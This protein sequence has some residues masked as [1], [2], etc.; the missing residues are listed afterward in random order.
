[1]R[2][3]ALVVA[4]ASAPMTAWALTEADAGKTTTV[5]VGEIVDL[6][7]VENP[8]TGYV[9]SLEVEPADAAAIVSSDWSRADAGAP[10]LRVGAPGIRTFNLA[11][12][13]TGNMTLR[14][15]L[16]R[17]WEGEK[18]VIQLQEFRLQTR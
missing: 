16:W 17:S 13:K 3:L 1:M 14:A 5:Q 2:R 7:L 10:G 6:N 11:V 18:S 12:K 8:S 4:L 15:K 9:W